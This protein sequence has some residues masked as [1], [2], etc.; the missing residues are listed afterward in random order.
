MSLKN[1]E[2]S[3]WL[4]KRR[5]KRL[6]ERREAPRRGKGGGI[7]V[8]IEIFRSVRSWSAGFSVERV[9]ASQS[10]LKYRRRCATQDPPEAWKGWRHLSRD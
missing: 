2:I 1:A 7:S 3:V 8:E 10:R 9:E 4:A 5:M 6:Q